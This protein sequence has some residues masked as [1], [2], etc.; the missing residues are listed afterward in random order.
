VIEKTS[1][2][3][4][5]AQGVMR[6]RLLTAGLILGMI[7]PSC[8]HPE[9]GEQAVRRAQEAMKHATTWKMRSVTPSIEGRLAV[10]TLD[11]YSC[12]SKRRHTDHYQSAPGNPQSSLTRVILT[13]DGQVYFF[14]SNMSRWTKGY[15]HSWDPPSKCKEL[16]DGL[17]PGGLPPLTM[18]L[19]SSVTKGE[20]QGTSAGRCQDWI[21]AHPNTP[22]GD[23]HLCLGVDDYLPRSYKA[24]PV[25]FQY[26][27]WNVPIDM[28]PPNLGE[29][30]AS[31]PAFP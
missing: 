7:S 2:R 23:E 31:P 11:E 21:L 10:E 4:I 29:Q 14:D 28:T 20:L 26:F 19:R 12:P 6:H 5:G 22:E 3:I 18:W 13:I 9:T 24:G 8:S 30:P 27:D 15:D 25:V 16:V 1:Q 17:D